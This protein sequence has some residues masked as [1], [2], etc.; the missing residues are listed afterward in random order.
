MVD[1]GELDRLDGHGVVVDPEHT[2]ALAGCRTKRAGE[3]REVVGGVQPVDGLPPMG[4]ID[5]IVPVRDEVP[6]RAALVAEGDAAVHAARRLLG[7]LGLGPGL[8][9]LAPVLDSR[10]DRPVGLLGARVLDET[11]DLTHGPPGD[12]IN[13][14]WAAAITASSTGVPV[15]LALTMALKTC[16]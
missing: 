7:E 13:Y 15:S 10:R 3:L 12:L 11:C 9:D 14:P 2:G 1:D 6:E 16:L 5:E 8:Q 4:A